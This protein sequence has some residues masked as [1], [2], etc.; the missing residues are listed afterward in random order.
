MQA[1]LGRFA[2][3]LEWVGRIASDFRFALAIGG[4]AAAVLVALLL[5]RSSQLVSSHNHSKEQLAQESARAF[6]QRVLSKRISPAIVPV[7]TA[8]KAFDENVLEASTRFQRLSLWNRRA[9]R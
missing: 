2:S 9:E 5:L 1:L 4:A 7:S 3:M 6:A 8:A